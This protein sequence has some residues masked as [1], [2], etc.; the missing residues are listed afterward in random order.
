LPG[1]FLTFRKFQGY[2]VTMPR[3]YLI[4]LLGFV[5]AAFIGYWLANTAVPPKPPRVVSS[6]STIERKEK[7]VFDDPAPKFRTG[8]R[9]LIR[10]R[11]EEAV[12][13]GALAGQRT[14]VFKDQAALEAFLKRA[15]DRV[16]VTGRLDQLNALRVSFLDPDDLA[17]LLGDDAQA[18]FVF[19]VD[20]PTLGEGTAQPG[21]V[22][23]NAGLL[24]WLGIDGDNSGWGAGVLIAILDTG[25]TQNKAFSSSIYSTN[26]VD[27]PG[28]LSTQNGHGT[29]VASMIIGNAPLT[30]GVAPGADIISIRIANDLG[31]SDTFLLA[32]G[33]IQAVDSGA[34]LINISMG[35]FGDSVL[36]R[37]AIEY[38]SAA[39][40]LIIASAGNNGT[41]Q[42]S[43]PAAYDGVIAVGAVDAMGNHLGFSN[44]GSQIS[45]SAPG[46]G[47]N[48][49]WTG[50]QAASVSGTSF[51]SPIVA[52]AIAA[53]MNR[54]AAPKLTARQAADLLYSYLNDSGEAGT[55]NK[56]GAGMPDLG[57]AIIGKKP[58][59]YDA[60][61]AS[62]RI[63][64]PSSGYPNGQIEV[65]VQNRGTE[66]LVNTKVRISTPTGVVDSNIT[67]LP[68]NGVQTIRV[69]INGN[70]DRE[71]HYDAK[72]SLT[73]GKTDVKP[74]NDRRVETYVPASGK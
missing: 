27:L 39:G 46:F 49:A 74:N 63:L 43:K 51:S 26:L 2:L 12:A 6:D 33:I 64:P 34:R 28:D 10:H 31:Q 55:D 65:L 15:G 14:L 3:R 54:P 42:V 24:E 11:D 25:V 8:D 22:S 70:V 41:D 69:P 62:Q 23:L 58:G 66:T 50:D 36:V 73:G 13:N 68:A 20:I 60:A 40:S 57:R 72:V 45:I 59:I 44:T 37:N 29:A 30:P 48:A 52:G 9:P 16:H 17:S 71:L 38:A 5:V 53:L 47:V 19:P 56:V 67:T 61:V 7:A 21:A 1:I 18:S 4:A 32:Q 35:G